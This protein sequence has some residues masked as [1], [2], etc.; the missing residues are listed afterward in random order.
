MNGGGRI[1]REY[2]LGRGRTDLLI[3]W[4]QGERTRRFVIE[5]KVLHKGLDRTIADGLEQTA[6][7]MDRC[8]A[9]AG[10][11]VIFDRDAGKTWE[12]K[13]FHRREPVGSVEIDVWGM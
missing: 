2:G 13:V 11:L 12:E 3:V 9:E 6:A 1:E 4:P 8:A 7:Y 5:C 10:H